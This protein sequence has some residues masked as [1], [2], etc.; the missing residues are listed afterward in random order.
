MG[1]LWLTVLLSLCGLSECWG[2]TFS[3]TRFQPFGVAVNPA[4]GELYANSGNTL[5]HIAAN[6]SA[7]TL[8][9]LFGSFL[10]IDPTGSF[11]YTCGTVPGYTRL[12]VIVQSAVNGS[13]VTALSPPGALELVDVFV[14]VNS[15]VYV[16][17]GFLTAWTVWKYFPNGTLAHNYTYTDGSVVGSHVSGVAADASGT[18]YMAGGLGTIVKLSADGVRL[19]TWAAPVVDLALDATASR[20]IGVGGAGL[21]TF[22]ASTGATLS[23]AA[24]NLGYTYPYTTLAVSPL[25]GVAYGTVPS[26]GVI[27]TFA[28]NGSYVTTL[29]IPAPHWGGI[30]WAILPDPSGNVYVS[31]LDQ[32]GYVFKISPSNVLLATYGPAFS[33]GAVEPY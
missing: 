12:S 6:G 13:F 5:W 25:T 7:S 9:P 2:P 11:L 33:C 31:S 27:A 23:S 14:D 30:I 15:N 16:A 20:V 3:Y 4:T 21:T 18:L 1:A 28:A 29:N 24:Y 22:N 17:D 10:A 8:F 32:P 26:A 19:L